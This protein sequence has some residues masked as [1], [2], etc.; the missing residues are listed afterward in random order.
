V[1]GTTDGQTISS[2]LSSGAFFGNDNLLFVNNGNAALDNS[3]V[4]FLLSGGIDVNLFLGVPHQ[5][6][7]ELFGSGPGGFVSEGQT[8]NISIT[9]PAPA[10]PEPATIALFAT[11]LLGMAGTIRRKLSV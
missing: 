3:G 11:G 4:S 1:T 5:Y 7:E 9:S 2:I 8:A 6:Q 10:V